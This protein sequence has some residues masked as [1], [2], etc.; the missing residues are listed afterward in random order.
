M[1]IPHTSDVDCNKNKSIPGWTE[2]V[3]PLKVKSLFSH[4]DWVDCDRP[5][6]GAVA[7]VMRRTRASYHLT[8]IRVRRNERNIINERIPDAMLDDNTRDF[9]SDAKRLRSNKTCPS[10][11]IDDFTSPCDIAKVR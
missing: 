7:D 6:T 9:W 11:M 4:N 5:K 1:V 2:Y 10:N 3:E 8:I